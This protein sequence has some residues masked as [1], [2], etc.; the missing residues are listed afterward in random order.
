MINLQ[1]LHTFLQNWNADQQREHPIAERNITCV[2]LWEDGT[3]CV[4]K[5]SGEDL[6]AGFTIA[7]ELFPAEIE[8][9]PKDS[10]TV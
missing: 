8:L 10:R 1:K 5:F 9:C 2:L 3:G 6:P 7:R 4:G